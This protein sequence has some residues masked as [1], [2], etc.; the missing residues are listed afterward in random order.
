MWCRGAA[1]TGRGHSRGILTGNN[2]REKTLYEEVED[3][4]QFSHY[5]T[6]EATILGRGERG[7]N[8]GL[9]EKDKQI[10]LRMTALDV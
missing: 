6:P 1:R 4:R 7:W 10:F 5:K 2:G 3:I 9:E 8:L